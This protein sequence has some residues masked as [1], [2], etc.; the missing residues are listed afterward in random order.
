MTAL[1]ET[2]DAESAEE[3]SR[4]RIRAFIAEH[5]PA[6]WR[7][8]GALDPDERDRFATWW[9][10]TLNDHGLMAV[11][12]PKEVGGSDLPLLDRVVLGE[13]LMRAGAAIW[14]ISVEVSMNLIGRTILEVGTPEQKARFLPPILAGTERWCQGFSEPNSGSDLASLGTRAVRDGDE[15]VI[16]GQKIW[17]SGADDSHWIFVLARTDT[18]APKHGGLTFFLVP[19]DQPGVEARPIR[20][21]NKTVDFCEVF[22]DGARTTSANILGSVGDGWNVAMTLLSFERGEGATTDAV[23][24][25]EEF[26]RLVRDARML[27]RNSDPLIRQRL[28]KLYTEVEIM[29]FLGQRVVQQLVSGGQIGPEGS[30]HKLVWSGFQQR[31]AELAVDIIGADAMTPSGRDSVSS[32]AVDDPG[33]PYSSQSWVTVLMASRSCTIRG[34]TTEIQRNIISEKVLGLPREPRADTGPWSQTRR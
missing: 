7:G 3:R 1:E 18:E 10:T 8:L 22:L 15:W 33:A 9:K 6:D 28:A 17:T 26:G 23:Q 21:I 12:W 5:L 31:L 30:L 20:N 14:D 29:R 32:I 2:T 25:R 16:S 34:G 27:G 4:R 24:Y 13:E 19:M 11:T